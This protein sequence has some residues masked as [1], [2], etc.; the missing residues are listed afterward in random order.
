ME[1]QHEARLAPQSLLPNYGPVDDEV[2]EEKN[3]EGDGG[4]VEA[5]AGVVLRGGVVR[6]SSLAGF[7]YFGVMLM[8]E[9]KKAAPPHDPLLSVCCSTE[10]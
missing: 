5:H 10:E 9:G 4:H 1:D 7:G 8:M 6:H 3:R 2:E